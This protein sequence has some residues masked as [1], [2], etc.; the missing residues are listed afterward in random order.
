MKHLRFVPPNYRCKV[1]DGD[2]QEYEMYFYAESEE[3]LRGTIERERFDLVSFEVYDFSEWQKR[4]A[5]A[6]RKAS[7]GYTRKDFKFS[8]HLW[9]EL[10]QYLFM[11]SGGACG[12][13]EAQVR[14]TG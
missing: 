5:E 9:A 3:D 10:K 14:I 8:N 13:C 7:S 4:A 1:A 12:Y 2:G 11:L 6:E